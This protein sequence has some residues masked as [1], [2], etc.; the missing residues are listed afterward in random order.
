MQETQ[1]R[2]IF[3]LKLRQLR[4][5]K[6]LSLFGLSKKTGLSKSYLNEIE[7]GKKYP[8]TDKI[9]LLAQA[10]DV[11]YDELVSLKLTGKMAPV[12]DLVTSGVLDEIPLELFGMEEQQLIDI[13]IN[14]PEKV[15]T[16]ISTIFQIARDHNVTRDYFYLSALKA[17]QE[18]NLNYFSTLEEEA[19]ATI[20][21][22]H[23]Y[24]AKG[25]LQLETLEELLSEEFRI[26]IDY[27]ALA[28]ANKIDGIRSVFVP[29]KKEK[30]IIDPDITDSQKAFLLCK[31][32]AYKR[33][34]LQVRPYTFTWIE[35]NSFEEVL[36]NFKAS[37]FAGA[38][39]LPQKKL[40]ADLQGFFR[41]KNWSAS[42][43]AA[44]ITASS[45]S[46]ETFFQRLTNV[47]PGFFGIESLFFLRFEGAIGS[48]DFELTKELH[49][50]RQHQPHANQLDEQY[51]RRWV[52]LDV[53]RNPQYYKTEHMEIGAQF[54]SYV[55]TDF[56]YLVISAR[57]EDPFKEGFFRSISI[58]IEVTPKLKKQ[59]AF[60]A[61]KN[62]VE[63]QVSVTC[64]TC[65][66]LD[67]EVRAAAPVRYLKSKR[68]TEIKAQI[69][70]LA[71]RIA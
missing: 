7:K 27:T 64:E 57:Q 10:L 39:L 50:S 66:I 37:Y 6:A 17:Y 60:L 13:M 29:G 53:L 28:D 68:D 5:A 48:D 26:T 19:E 40:V 8:K 52:A 46:V 38:L 2:T 30:L 16:F 22:Y 56:K 23:L 32:L 15:N 70:S 62:I 24:D 11:D 43:F 35:F 20:K 31:E 71:E 69:N 51:C 14:A 3:G 61:D 33:L 34:G 4:E 47:L 45:D 41:A 21:R 44:L 49:L 36:N 65:P 55:N 12:A 25:Q 58:G 67:C 9:L 42:N 63:K 18:A 1:I 59:V 54:S